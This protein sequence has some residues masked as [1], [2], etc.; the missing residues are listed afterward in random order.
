MDD[1][2][3]AGIAVVVK[4]SSVRDPK[5]KHVC[6]ERDQEWPREKLNCICSRRMAKWLTP[7]ISVPSQYLVQLASHHSSFPPLP[8]LLYH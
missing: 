6:M 8:S 2:P 3:P 1:T 5:E 7:F 4:Y